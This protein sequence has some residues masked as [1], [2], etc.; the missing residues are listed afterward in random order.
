M[1][2]VTLKTSNNA[3]NLAL[4]WNNYYLKSIEIEKLFNHFTKC[5]F[6]VFL[7]NE[8]HEIY[9]LHLN[10]FDMTQTKNIYSYKSE[11]QLQKEKKYIQIKYIHTIYTVY[12]Y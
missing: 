1:D 3:E 2:H 12:V 9:L 4:P 6:N 10:Q 7:I 11:K 8:C 5:I